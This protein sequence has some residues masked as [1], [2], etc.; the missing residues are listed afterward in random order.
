MYEN[1]DRHM[2]IW[3]HHKMT[4]SAPID[5]VRFVWRGTYK[6]GRCIYILYYT[7][8][9]LYRPS[10][11]WRQM[12]NNSVQITIIITRIPAKRVYIP[13][14]AG[15]PRGREEKTLSK[16][17]TNIKNKQTTNRRVQQSPIMTGFVLYQ[18]RKLVFSRVRVSNRYLS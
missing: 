10:K 18:I 13:S 5:H 4:E 16:R 12:N 8:I 2:I 15:W 14:C 6:L 9:L 7:I 1:C 17:R 11:I 3:Y